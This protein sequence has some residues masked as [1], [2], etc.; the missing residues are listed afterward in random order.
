M[1][2]QWKIVYPQICPGPR[3]QL[4]RD[5]SIRLSALVAEGTNQ[6]AM[7]L[8]SEQI[9]MLGARIEPVGPEKTAL[10][11][12]GILRTDLPVRKS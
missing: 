9:K 1:T 3:R 11:V 7:F 6:K 8:C 10:T 5:L 4:I 12:K 2:G